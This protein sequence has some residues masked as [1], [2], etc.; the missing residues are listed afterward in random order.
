MGVL[1]A[2]FSDAAAAPPGV[3]LDDPFYPLGGAT[4]QPGPVQAGGP[5]IYLGGQGPRGLALAARAAQGW[6]VPGVNANDPSYLRTKR[7]DLLGRLATEG[8]I[9][10]ASTSWRRSTSGTTGRA[11][12]RP[13]A[14]WSATGATHLMLGMRPALGVDELR[15]IVDDVARPLRDE[16][17]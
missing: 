14:R 17:G 6:L 11:R 2:L 13:R 7:D 3:T 4:L 5:P 1:R 15:R 9:P 16:L 10:T 12:S 8:R